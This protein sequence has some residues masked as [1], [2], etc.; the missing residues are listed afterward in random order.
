MRKPKKQLSSIAAVVV[1]L[2]GPSSV[3][4]LVRRSPP[5]NCYWRDKKGKFPA[6][7]WPTMRKELRARGFDAP[8]AIWD[9]EP[10]QNSAAA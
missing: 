9:F 8:R 4:R 2:G 5:Q 1:A 7:F 3:G 6:R 10:E